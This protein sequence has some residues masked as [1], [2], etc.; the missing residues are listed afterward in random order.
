MTR[1]RV[2]TLAFLLLGT[3]TALPAQGA[4]LDVLDGE[5]LY[6]GGWLAT[7]GHE[8]QRRDTLRTGSDRVADPLATHELEQRTTLGVQYG[9]RHDLQLGLSLSWAHLE[10]D[11]ALGS[12]EADGFGDLGLLVKYRFL[13]LDERGSAT[14]FSVLGGVSLPTGDDDQQ[15]GGVE[16]PPDL[17]P[18]TGSVD[19]ML[20]AAVTHEPGRWRFNAAL[21][22]QLHTDLDDDGDRRGDE[23]LLELAAGNRFWLEPYPGPFMRLDGIVRWYREGRDRMDGPLP[24]TGGERLAAGLNWAFRP[25]PEFDIQVYAEVPVHEHVRGTQL[26]HDWQLDITFGYR[27]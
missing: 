7:I 25:R 11:S 24:D 12:Q 19:P 23:L 17:Q 9:L 5:T 13:R 10:A 18:G 22:W 15:S 27:F 4:I 8:L 3:A 2:R 21:M 20:G 14:N 1:M 16:L 6:D 26:G